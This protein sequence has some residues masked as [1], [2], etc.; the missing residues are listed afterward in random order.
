VSSTHLLAMHASN[1]GRFSHSR[2]LSST[3]R[4]TDL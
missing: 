2:L 4:R 1:I 3:F